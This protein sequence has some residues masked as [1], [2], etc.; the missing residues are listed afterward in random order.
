MDAL[1]DYPSAPA[2][3][4]ALCAL[5]EV[6]LRTVQRL[7]GSQRTVP[8]DSAATT[9]TKTVGVL[10]GLAARVMRLSRLAAKR[11]GSRESCKV[12]RRTKCLE[13]LVSRNKPCVFA[14]YRM[15]SPGRLNSRR[16]DRVGPNHRPT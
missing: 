12:I 11:L 16:L 10:L 8:A 6:S 2:R 7:F 5:F 3:S 13:V 4:G 9:V 14:R 15:I 1:T